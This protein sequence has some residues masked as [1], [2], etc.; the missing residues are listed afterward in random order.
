MFFFMHIMFVF[1]LQFSI[2]S[3]EDVYAVKHTLCVD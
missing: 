2:V 1:A 3:Q